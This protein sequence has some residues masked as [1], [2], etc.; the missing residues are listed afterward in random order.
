MHQIY[1]QTDKLMNT[2]T[3][4]TTI[5]ILLPQTFHHSTTTI[6]YCKNYLLYVVI[7]TSVTSDTNY[8]NVR[9]KLMP[10]IIQISIGAKS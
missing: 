9:K 8:E 2:I 3:C 4:M 1:N 7:S 10:T 6:D 5:D